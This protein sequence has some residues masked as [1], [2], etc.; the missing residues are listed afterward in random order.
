MAVITRPLPVA[1]RPKPGELI[2]SWLG[3]TAARYDMDGAAFR[4]LLLPDDGH[5]RDRLDLQL[6]ADE[7]TGLADAFRLPPERV[8]ALDLTQ[9]WPRVAVDWLPGVGRKMRARGNLDLSWCR[10]CLEEGHSSSGTYLDRE[11]ALPLCLCHRHQHWRV[12]CCQHCSP[13]NPPRFVWDRG[14]VELACG[15]CRRLL[16]TPGR[17]IWA[18]CWGNDDRHMGRKFEIMLVFER[19]LRSGL[20]GHPVR[21]EG[22]GRVEP[23]EFLALVEDLTRALLAPN[24]SSTSLI[25]RYGCDFL[26][27]EPDHRPTDWRERPYPELG[28]MTRAWVLSAIIAIV[29]GGTI[30]LLFSGRYRAMHSGTGDAR[31]L[32]W[33]FEH[34]ATWVKAM[35]IRGSARWPAPLRE[36]MRTLHAGSGLEVDDILIR[37]ETWRAEEDRVRFGTQRADWEQLIDWSWL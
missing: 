20:L 6:T 9:A 7:V 17:P 35:L 13:D 22:V 24:R 14:A 4:P 8:A 1:P 21:I 16:R 29:S 26:R 27:I 30:G 32:E 33:L 5:G 19:C 12:D 36:R 37:F 23:A 31:S 10:K 3:R 11:A 2:S 34:A 28:P 18:E 15:D 25:N